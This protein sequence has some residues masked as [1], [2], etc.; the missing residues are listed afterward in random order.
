MTINTTPS[1]QKI[2]RF[3]HKPYIKEGQ[4]HNATVLVYT[5]VSFECNPMAD[6]EPFMQW[7]YHD[8]SVGNVHDGNLANGTII[9]VSTGSQMFWKSVA[10]NGGV[11]M[12]LELNKYMHLVFGDGSGNVNTCIN[13]FYEF[14][15]F[16][17]FRAVTP[18][19]SIYRSSSK[20]YVGVG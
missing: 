11:R 1:I 15:C 4:P 14:T 13:L 2:E 16:F 20:S 18:S 3:P 19:S 6:L 17:Y 10:C 12:V 5:N 7:Y 8:P 9:Q